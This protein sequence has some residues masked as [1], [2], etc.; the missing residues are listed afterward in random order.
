M[1]S[2][3]TARPA[4]RRIAVLTAAALSAAIASK[5]SA[6]YRIDNS[7]ARDA[8][9]RI[10]SGGFNGTAGG[11]AVNS[12]IN[13]NAGN[14][15]V[16]GNV[17]GGRAFRGSLGYTDT[18]QF[19][20]S[21][22]SASFDN[23]Y[24]DSVGFGTARG[25]MGGNNNYATI[26]PYFGAG[27]TVTQPNGFV[28]DPN[29]GGGFVPAPRSTIQSNDARVDFGGATRAE[30]SQGVISSSR[31]IGGAGFN[32][33]PNSI[34]GNPGVLGSGIA[35]F[36]V[37]AGPA[38][39][40]QL[41]EYTTLARTRPGL[42]N[43]PPGSDP[44][45]SEAG[46]N[47][48]RNAEIVDRNVLDPNA[49]GAPTAINS[50]RDPG[51]LAVT[52]IDGRLDAAAR[53]YDP[54][55]PA[56]ANA[57]SEDRSALSN[58]GQYAEL[59]RRLEAAD[60]TKRLPG[61]EAVDQANANNRAVL[62]QRQ[63]ESGKTDANT[64]NS[65]NTRTARPGINAAGTQ[66]PGSA[67]PGAE[68]GATGNRSTGVDPRVN[69]RVEPTEENARP[70]GGQRVGERIDTTGV[71][72]ESTVA[73]DNLNLPRPQG[74]VATPT[75]GPAAVQDPNADASL[76]IK[77]LATDVKDAQLADSLRRAE[78]LMK[79]GKFA[80]AIDLYERAR[81]AAKDDP[82][83]FMGQGIAELG[84]GYYGK[85]EAHIR[86][87]FAADR[88]LLFAKFDLRELLGDQRLNFL[89][90]DLGE[91]ART[92]TK[93]PG[94]LLLLAFI[95][96][97]GG[98]EDRAATALQMAQTRAGGNDPTVSMLQQSWKLPT[99]QPGA[100]TPTELTK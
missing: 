45:N 99:Q 44:I 37:S 72:N 64:N 71:K 66:A 70:I 8:N 51:A 12:R 34:S 43:V 83:V 88:A 84:G 95:Y 97:N 32:T 74:T 9:N 20:G 10:G 73:P 100:P 13:G 78:V 50:A 28:R 14:Y 87:A 16:T 40:Y 58:N 36:D 47:R 11:G 76:R 39:A 2:P 98:M 31:V 49:V 30:V 17:T 79:D 89:V 6:Q 60:R 62:Q 55:N 57:T 85:S 68:P 96:Y 91:T 82:I 21:L 94:P 29:R 61:S 15:I 46:L 56:G 19:R 41:S 59:R 75:T 77:S 33:A 92:N 53:P 81:G 27:S 26:Q 69:T 35:P 90:S 5:A 3:N 86:Q 42:L 7:S 52:P 48:L 63:N 22:G 93:N 18:T 23:F 4:A 1:T 65:T 67:T 54:S 80:T 25:A 38:S 24:R